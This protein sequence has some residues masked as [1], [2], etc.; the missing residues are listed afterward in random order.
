MGD[1][2]ANNSRVTVREM[3][4]EMQKM[5]QRILERLEPL[6]VYCEKTNTLEKEVDKLRKDSNL[7]DWIL[8]IGAAVG[9]FLGIT[10]KA[11]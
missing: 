2:P 7:R 9:T 6:A 5:E 8:G 3:Y 10:I 11:P 4:H 1:T